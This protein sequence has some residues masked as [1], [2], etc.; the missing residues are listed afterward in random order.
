ML[1]KILF[2]F[3]Q[4]YLIYNFPIILFLFEKNI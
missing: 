3:L 1:Y 4:I 2:K